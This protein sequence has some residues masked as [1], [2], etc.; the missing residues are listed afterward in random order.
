MDENLY[1]LKK[2]KNDIASLKLFSLLLKPEQKQKLKEMETQLHHMTTQI[3]LFNKRFSD[4]GWCAYDTM[5][6]KLLEDANNSFESSGIEDG[7]KILLDYYKGDV[8]NVIHWL[9]AKSS[10]LSEWDTPWT[11]FELWK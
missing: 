5:N 7:E 1:S 2:L 4:C 8:R 3:D 6:F 10:T 9:K 11:G